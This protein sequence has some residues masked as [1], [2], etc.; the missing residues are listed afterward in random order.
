MQLTKKLIENTL[1]PDTGQIFLRDDDVSGLAV[2]VTAGGAKTWVLEMRVGGRPKRMT[3]G[4]WGDH[5]VAAARVLA[6]EWRGAIG[7]GEDPTA[8]RNGKSLRDESTFAAFAERFVEEHSKRR[9]RSWARDAAR[10]RNLFMRWNSRHLSEIKRED[11]IGLQ[12]RIA[13]QH[14]EVAANRA[15]SLL[16]TMFNTAADWGVYKGENP[17]A[18]VRHYKE[19]SRVRYLDGHELRRVNEALANQ[20]NEY[21]RAYFALLLLLGLRRNELLSARWADVDFEGR[22]L[23]IPSTKSG[24]V[25]RAPL[26]DAAIEILRSLSSCGNHE[27]IFPSPF[28]KGHLVEPGKAWQRIRERAGV[29]DVTIHDLRRTFGSWLAARGFSLAMIGVALN[30]SDPKST[31]I[32]AKI[33]LDP[34]RAMIESNAGAML[35]RG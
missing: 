18:R 21:W 2:R 19:K 9:K 25:H 28:G 34:V 29:A 33:N 27:F 10:I 7:R 12:Q 20:P 23:T 11:V 14:G 5:D 3:L 35:Q 26:P 30:H 13:K 8:G 1:P 22:V 6:H 24:E 15:T 4:R 32:Y 31:R 16:C 17:A